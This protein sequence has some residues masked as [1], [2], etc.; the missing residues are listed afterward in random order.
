MNRVL[1]IFKKQKFNPFSLKPL[2][3]PK[4]IRMDSHQS[5]KSMTNSMNIP[6]EKRAREQSEK[7]EE[8]SQNG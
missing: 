6:G 7:S 1:R 4:K 3:I 5:Q 2:K 8:R